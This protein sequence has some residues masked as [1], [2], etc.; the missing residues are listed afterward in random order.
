VAGTAGAD[1]FTVAPVANTPWRIVIAE[2]S[3]HLFAS[4]SGFA[5]WLPWIVFALVSVFGLLLLG[6][7]TRSLAD[8]ARLLALSNMMSTKARTDWLTGA[9]NRRALNEHLARATAYARRHGEPLSVMMVDLDGFK[10]TN[11]R[12]G[13]AA[14]DSVLRAVSECMRTILRADDV[15]GR[16]GGDEFAIILPAIDEMA[17]GIAAERLHDAAASIDLGELGAGVRL[18]I[19]KAT[20]VH[21]SPDALTR[22]ADLDL[23]RAKS[24][25]RA[26]RTSA[27]QA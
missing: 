27:V 26:A 18:S 2:P 9:Y 13:H 25:K 17:V 6:L 20:G 14:G 8:R 10:Q 12:F 7:L 24:A 15:F 21:T 5:A 4:I 22:A 23:Y 16:W 1:T 19:G 3:S 11:D